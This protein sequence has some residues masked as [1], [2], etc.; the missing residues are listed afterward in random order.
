M[1][2]FIL[3]LALYYHGWTLKAV[4]LASANVLEITGD[5]IQTIYNM[6]V[7]GDRSWDYAAL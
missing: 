5:R 4:A 1:R 3:A 2:K 6:I 7:Q